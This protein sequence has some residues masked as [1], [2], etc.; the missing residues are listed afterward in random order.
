M[1]PS[2]HLTNIISLPVSGKRLPQTGSNSTKEES[3]YV[4]E[5]CVDRIR[6]KHKSQMDRS[7]ALRMSYHW[8]LS[9]GIDILT[10][11]HRSSWLFLCSTLTHI[12]YFYIHRYGRTPM[13]GK[14]YYP[15]WMSYPS[16]CQNVFTVL[17]HIGLLR[18]HTKFTWQF[19]MQLENRIQYQ[20]ALTTD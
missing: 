6:V 17:E 11:Y 9:P 2:W 8:W 20:W 14:R 4:S 7:Y 19:R 5:D 10:Q 1:A 3:Q 18:I 13:E 12:L 16:E 15:W